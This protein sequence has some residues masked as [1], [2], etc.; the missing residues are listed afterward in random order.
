MSSGGRMDKKAVVH[1]HKGTFAIKKNSSKEVDE[2]GAY[3]TE[4]SKSERKTPIQYTNTYMWKLERQWRWPCT[5]DSRRDRDV[6]NRLLESVGEGEGGMIWENSIE[7]CISSCE[8][9]YCRSDAGDRALRAGALGWPWGMAWG[10][11][12]EGGSGWGTHVHPW[13]IHVN[14]WQKLLHY[15]EVISL[16]LKLID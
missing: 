13:L 1:I 11:R 15:C 9:D 6:K 3:Y 4:Q 7:T 10:R 12:W 5:W 14:V 16:Q 8:R 2:T